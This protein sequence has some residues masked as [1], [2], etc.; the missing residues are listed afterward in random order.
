MSPATTRQLTIPD[1]FVVGTRHQ[2][3]NVRGLRVLP[4]WV[5]VPDN[6]ALGSPR[7]K[8]CI[9]EGIDDMAAIVRPQRPESHRLWQRQ[10]HLGHLHEI[11]A[12]AIH[13]GC[14]AQAV[15]LS[16][17]WA[18]VDARAPRVDSC[19]FSAFR[20]GSARSPDWAWNKQECRK[21]NSLILKCW[22]HIVRP[23]DDTPNG[24]RGRGSVLAL[25]RSLFPGGRREK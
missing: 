14:E 12:Y 21:T 6:R 2:D 5:A 4:K 10:L 24:G 13:D 16:N 17:V 23:C 3:R 19:C 15:A 18:S 7:Q 9:H 20:G 1:R 11:Q 25:T 22:T 8:T